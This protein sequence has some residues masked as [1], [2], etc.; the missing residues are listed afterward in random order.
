MAAREKKPEEHGADLS[1][2]RAEAVL[3]KMEERY[4]YLERKDRR[5][6]KVNYSAMDTR[7]TLG[8]ETIPDL[9]AESVEDI[10]IHN[11]MRERL[12]IEM[13]K[14]SKPERE[15]IYALYF[16]DLTERE[17]AQVIGVSQKAV[18]R[19]RKSALCKLHKYLEK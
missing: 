19:R 8:E 2:G 6:G 5:H 14:L 4:K 15:L 1:L 12:R 3:K 16:A 10:A 13:G 9:E 17:Y 11:I 18:N 7:E